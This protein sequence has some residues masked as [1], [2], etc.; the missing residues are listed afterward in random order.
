MNRRKLLQALTTLTAGSAWTLM[1]GSLRARDV[2]ESS[3][4]GN[5]SL[6]LALAESGSCCDLMLAQNKSVFPSRGCLPVEVLREL[7]CLIGEAR[8]RL[9]NHRA[10]SPAFWQACGDACLRVA[11]GVAACRIPQSPRNSD[12]L[13]AEETFRRTAQL[14]TLEIIRS[15]RLHVACNPATA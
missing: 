5:E 11:E 13:D 8:T 9:M 3:W 4:P 15:T 14:L 1:S 6:L 7:S 10:D 2:T 12:S